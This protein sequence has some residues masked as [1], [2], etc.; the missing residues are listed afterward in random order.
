MDKRKVRL[1]V[2]AMLPMGDAVLIM[3][4]VV[5]AYYARFFLPVVTVKYGVPEFRYYLA[6]APFIAIVFILSMNYAGLYLQ[7][8]VRARI[9]SF[10]KVAAAAIAGTTV[11]LALTFFIRSF[12]FS[13]IVMIFML[14]L[15]VLYI[16]LWR[17][18]YRA[19]FDYLARKDILIRK[20]LVLGTTPVSAILI[21]RLLRDA[22]AGLRV[23]GCADNKAKKG[24][25]FAGV[26]VLGKIK[27]TGRLIREN[28]VDEVFIGLADYSRKEIAEII[29]ECEG[30]KFM[31]ASDLLGLMTKSIEYN[32]IS[33]IP[34][35]TVKELPLDRIFN[36]FLKRFMDI[37]VSGAG[38]IILSPVLLLL[39]LLV[40][41]SSPGPV[42]Y[43]QERVG[44]NNKSFMMRK[45]R[46]M[47]ADAEKK[48]GPKWADKDDPRRTPI[49]AFLRK[50]SLDELPQLF[51]IFYGDMSL[52][53]PRPERPHFVREFSKTVPRYM[54][55][56]KVKSGLTGW[57]QVN[58]LR[59]NTSLEERVSYDLYY[60]ENWSL[61]LDIKIII[62]TALE[63]F[64]HDSAY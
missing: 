47:R 61:W 63:V 1:I 14:L 62:K 44:R 59:G 37:A 40:K 24:K 9:D 4:A 8:A 5:S 15:S 20:I 60:I 19:F 57:A 29:M 23:V 22:S 36:R 48:S 50:T 55:R 46:S 41:L 27:D 33:G 31:I 7:A 6:A 52:V 51:N 16:Y 53:G 28:G 11:L 26:K 3:L 35:F 54:E 12:T 56:H 49:G 32:E 64:H 18:A 45:F 42:F 39:A 21:E 34:V 30:V 58:G 25:V 43:T 10:F 17:L 13:R 38:I 2:S